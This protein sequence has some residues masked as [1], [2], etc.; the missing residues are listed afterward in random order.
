MKV[1]VLCEFS[2]TVRDAFIRRGHEAV[3]CDVLKTISP[4]PHIQG[5][6]L[7]Q[8]WSSYDLIIAHPPCTFLCSASNYH[9][10][11]QEWKDGREKAIE[12]V[13]AISR[14]PVNRIA[15]ENPIGILTSRFR[16]PDQ[17]FRAY[18]FGHPFKKDTCLWLKNLPN[19]KPTGTIGGP[20]RTFDFWSKK[21]KLPGGGCRKSITFLNVATAMA[22]QWGSL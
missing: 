6:C 10:R 21:R 20:Y 12:F 11:K 7:S 3:S 22:E 2:G 19:L 17:V 4:G 16:K 5:D 1:A 8:D 15:I 9:I 13:V 14:L 18:E